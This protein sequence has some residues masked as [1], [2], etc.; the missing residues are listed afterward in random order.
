MLQR[1]AEQVEYF[2]V[3]DKANNCTDP[4][5]K[6]AYA[7][8]FGF[9]G[10]A[11]SV[12]R[13]KKPFNPILGET[14]E[15]IPEDNSFFFISEQVSHHPPISAGFCENQNFTWYGDSDVKGS[16]MIKSLEFKALGTTHIIL[17]KK[18][19]HITYKRPTITI[20]NILFGKMYVDYYGEMPFYNNTTGDIAVLNFKQRGWT[21]KDAYVTEGSV[22]DKNGNVKYILVGKWDS[23]LKAINPETKAETTIWNANKLGSDHEK[24]FSFGDFQ[25]QLN[26]LPSDMLSKLCPTDSRFRTDQRA[27]EYGDRQLAADEKHRLEEKQRARRKEMKELGQTHEARWFQHETDPVTGEKIYKYKGGYIEARNKRAFKETLDLFT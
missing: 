21:G 4:H 1:L 24:E 11:S 22:K 23:Y 26:H 25:R 18:N 8:A 12:H 2:S 13:T 3:L 15:L 6:M 14:Y 16:F 27:Y 17:K 19:D 20:N 9:S 5:L 10:F 7:A